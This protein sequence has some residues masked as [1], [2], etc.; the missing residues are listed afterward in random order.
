MKTR[1]VYGW[2]LSMLLLLAAG[3]GL[4]RGSQSTGPSEAVGGNAS[5]GAAAPWFI[6]TV[7]SDSDLGVG[8]HVSVAIDP[9]GTT[10]ISY[11]DA[12]NKDLKMAK[13]VGSGGNCG[14]DNDW[15]CETVDDSSNDVGKYS[16]IAIDPTTN[17]PV[18][19]Y[20][21]K[22]PD[23]LRLA[24]AQ[25]NGWDIVTIDGGPGRY[26]SLKIDS[27]GAAHIAYHRYG[28]LYKLN[29]A[30]HVSGGAGNCGGNDYQCDTI[31]ADVGIVGQY[32][33]LALSGADQPR[34][35]YYGGNNAL[36]YAY[37]SGGSWTIREI[38]PTTLGRHFSLA[39]DVNNGDL[40]HIAHYDGASGKLGYA[41]YVETGGNCGVLDAWQC[42]EIDSMGTGSHTR[43]VSLAVDRAGLP[44]I[45]YHKYIIGNPFS[46]VTFNLA[47][48]AEALRLQSGNCGPQDSWQCERIRDSGHS[49]DYS[50]IAVHPS[51]LATIAYYNTEYFGMLRVA[52][53][54]FRVSL[55]VVMK[56]Q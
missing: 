46:I 30:R 10:Y 32:P 11:Y 3:T 14:P 5:P 20:W 45:A 17:L 28:V 33:S 42:D 51:G 21:N 52:Y 35:A 37:Q 27:T 18:I 7:D 47:R 44:I 53:Q 49:G 56:N 43:D 24:T 8:S 25:N 26:A 12:T 39:V 13:H 40:P 41:V 1:N 55:P 4:A 22:T 16:S 48:P 54:R 29:Y 36:M 9:A 34:I 23:Y 2:I 31:D 50:A 6:E 15:S 38:L 19:A